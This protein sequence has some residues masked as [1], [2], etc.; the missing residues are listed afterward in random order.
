MPKSLGDG[1]RESRGKDFWD[2]VNSIG[3]YWV[4]KAT[5]IV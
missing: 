4:E 2:K 3:K 1:T 5:S